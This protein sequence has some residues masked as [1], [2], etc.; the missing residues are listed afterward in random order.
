ML[1]TS[2]GFCYRPRDPMGSMAMESERVARGPTLGWLNDRIA[3][4]PG[5]A[6]APRWNKCSIVSC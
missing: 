2:M 6:A 5:D 3:A 1:D 4:R